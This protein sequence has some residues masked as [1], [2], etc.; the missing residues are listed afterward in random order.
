MAP[1]SFAA[2]T[3][4]RSSPGWSAYFATLLIGCLSA[5]V[6]GQTILR[7]AIGP[8]TARVRGPFAQIR[9]RELSDGRLLFTGIGISVVDFRSGVIRRI[10]R[11]GKGPLE[12]NYAGVNVYPLSHDSS[13]VPDAGKWLVLDGDEVVGSVVPPQ[14]RLF[15]S[16]GERFVPDTVG[17]S[18][19]SVHDP[20]A[21][22]SA[23][24]I[25][26]NRSSGHVDTIGTVE[27]ER[28]VIA[29][30]VW[31][32]PMP[33][34][35]DFAVQHEDGW[36]S[37]TRFGEYRVDWWSPGRGFVRGGAL[38]FA[39]VKIDAAERK[40]LLDFASK[41][42]VGRPVPPDY[43]KVWRDI[44]PPVFPLSSPM[45]TIP[46][47]D[48]RLLIHR[49]P[50]TT[51]PGQTYDVV[52]R[53]GKL[54]GRLFLP[55]NEKVVGFGKRSVYIVEEDENGETWLRRHSWPPVPRKR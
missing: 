42:L 1:T 25:R 20:R 3:S 48:G 16:D 54:D 11:R 10:T 21:L 45:G 51:E 23:T 2:A 53:Q 19:G 44:Y 29:S 40:F 6:A 30:N 47:P 35:E 26:V 15:P 22:S 39:P 38:P 31:N 27:W 50:N 4:F 14:F 43:Y 33:P 18:S 13:I 46:T 36:I 9:V 12:H 28:A 41:R 32:Y 34:A 5:P 17:F 7:L 55:E 37:F 8:A 24:M 52:N 49:S